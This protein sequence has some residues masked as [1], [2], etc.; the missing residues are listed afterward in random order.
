MNELENLR[1]FLAASESGS[2][3]EGANK[4]SLSPAAFGQRIRQ[5]E[6]ALGVE[7]F[8]RTTRTIQ[9][10][11]EGLQLLPEAE[12]SVRVVEECLSRTRKEQQ[13]EITMG[14]R[15]ELGMSWV[16]PMLKALEQEGV[17]IHLYV[18]SGVDLLHKVR[19]GMIHCAVT[20]TRLHDPLLTSIPLHEE[21]YTFVG[22]RNYLKKTPLRNVKDA[23]K[24]TLV[25]LS[26]ELPLYRYWRDG[27]GAFD[28]SKFRNLRSMGT[29]ESVR[30]MVLAGQGVAV[31][32]SYFVH[33]DVRSK[34]LRKVL[35]NTAIRSDWF[36]L[37]FLSSSQL[38]PLFTRLASQMQKWP[39]T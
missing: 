36:R 2:F 6:E 28:A 19:T 27:N 23:S 11:E 4:V 34:R 16:V 25:D 5:L 38:R 35:V 37:V 9:L 24:H 3:R 29:I 31:L 13:I 30:A 17:Y 20:S 10:T 39:L 33:H 21:Q 32:P 8:F 7:L 22:E 12:N 14:T 18:G 26:S 1:C 15:H